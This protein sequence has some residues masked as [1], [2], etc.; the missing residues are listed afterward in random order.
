MYISPTPFCSHFHL[1]Y[2]IFR[3]IHEP[4]TPNFS[5][6]VRFFD[7][8]VVSVICTTCKIVVTRTWRSRVMLMGVKPFSD[9]RVALT[10][11]GTLIPSET[12]ESTNYQVDIAITNLRI[13]ITLTSLLPS[14]DF[15]ILFTPNS[16]SSCTCLGSQASKRVLIS[17]WSLFVH[18][19][20]M[21]PSH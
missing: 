5:I 14:V 8:F 9:P 19:P 16:F 12:G 21:Y 15:N 2:F 3:S 10:A 6:L 17:C 13:N 7:P 20:I 4:K 11:F 18:G 1:T